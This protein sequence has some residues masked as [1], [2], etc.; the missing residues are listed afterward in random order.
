MLLACIE[1]LRDRH[2]FPR[3]IHL[4]GDPHVHRKVQRRSKHAIHPRHRRDC[5][6]IL[7]RFRRL[8]LHRDKHFF[9]GLGHVFH[10]VHARVLA[11]RPAQ[12]H[13]AV[14]QRRVLCIR[15]HLLGLFHRV[16][17]RHQDPRR[18]RV[19][20]LHDRFAPDLRHPHHH[21]NPRAACAG[22]DVRHRLPV[23]R[24]VLHVDHKKLKTRLRQQV[25]DVRVT[26]FGNDRPQNQVPALELFFKRLHH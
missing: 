5:V 26:H 16:H 11:V 22:D 9:V 21:R 3:V 4:P 10:G 12:R 1:H 6:R 19:K 24:A 7:D 20:R 23:V 25:P 14:A 17:H 18:T 2:H 13:A 8:R 15:H